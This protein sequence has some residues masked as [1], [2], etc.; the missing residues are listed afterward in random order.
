MVADHHL[1]EPGSC[2]T[3]EDYAKKVRTEIQGASDHPK[4]RAL[5]DALQE[6]VFILQDDALQ[7][8]CSPPK[9]EALRQQAIGVQRGIDLL[10]DNMSA[11]AREEETHRRR[12]MRTEGRKRRHE[13]HATRPGRFAQP[14]KVTHV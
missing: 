7:P 10:F 3:F 14:Q 4:V 12:S 1:Y 2:E 9:A 11:D 5:L 8:T 6:L 13:A